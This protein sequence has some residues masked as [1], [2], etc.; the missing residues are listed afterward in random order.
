MNTH[1]KSQLSPSL[2]DLTLLAQNTMDT[3]QKRLLRPLL[4]DLALTRGYYKHP[5]EQTALPLAS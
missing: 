5:P 3:H 2:L 1:Q 4:L